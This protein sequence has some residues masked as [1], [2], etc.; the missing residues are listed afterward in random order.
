MVYFNSFSIRKYKLCYSWVKMNNN[1]SGICHSI[2][3]ISK[4]STM[5]Y[6]ICVVVEPD[7]TTAQRRYAIGGVVLLGALRWNIWIVLLLTQLNNNRN[8]IYHLHQCCKG[9]ATRKN[10]C[11]RWVWVNNNTEVIF[12]SIWFKFR[13]CSVTNQIYDIVDSK[14]IIKRIEFVMKA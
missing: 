8:F 1:T 6:S 12:Q 10:L 11:C 14:S 3:Y 2:I 7:S 13:F 5:E 9:H 4:C